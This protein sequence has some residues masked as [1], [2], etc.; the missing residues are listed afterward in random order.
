MKLISLLIFLAF[1]LTDLK[2]NP[3]LPDTLQVIQ[4]IESAQEHQKNGRAEA[5][6][7]GLRKAGEMAKELNFQRG[8]LMYAGHYTVFL[9]NQLRYEEAL[10]M[11]HI[12]LEIASRLNDLQRIGYAYNNIS[13]QYQAMGKLQ[14][15]ANNLMNALEISSRV[16]NPGAAHL[17]DRRK[18]YNNLSSLLLDMNDL[19]K[20]L[21]YA[22][23]A[24]EIAEELQDSV[25]MGRS[26]V[27]ILVAEAMAGKLARAESHGL[28]LQAI[29]EASGDIEMIMKAY[30]NL[31]DIYRMQGRYATSLETF[32][33]AQLLLNKLPPGHEVYVTMGMS[34][35]YKDMGE[36][37]KADSHFERA[38]VLAREELAKPQLIELFLSGAEIKE[39][40]GAYR[41][42]LLL[43]KQ[44]ELLNDS[45]RNQETH[46]SIQELEV[47]YQTAEKE[48]ALAERDLM[49]SEQVSELERKNKWFFLSAAV[50]FLLIILVVFNRLITVQ[51][52]KTQVSEQA[53]RILA[54]QL[55]GEE[56][57]RARTARELHDGV[58]S[59]LSAAKLHINA[60]DSHDRNAFGLVGQLI[61]TA[62]QEVRNISHNLAPGQ[63]LDEGLSSATQEFCRRM[64]NSQLQF[65]FYQIGDLPE[66]DKSAELLLY[67]IIQETV[68]NVVKHADA[69]EVI[70]QLEGEG[71]LLSITIEDNG[72]GFDP[73]GLGEKG[74]GLKNLAY[75]IQ[76]L[77][78]TYE[79]NSS[80][81]KGTSVY[82]YI[83]ASK[84]PQAS[85]QRLE[86][87]YA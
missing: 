27:N 71:S 45:L 51:K 25:A 11:A 53:N 59:I 8:M 17:G 83:D 58:A 38:L 4:L 75:R 16:E 55:Q 57:E 31:G 86:K 34:A 62:V 50:A 76:V 81:G 22:Q 70:V 10:E 24:Y 5:A 41:D 63:V 2:G 46:A 65:E 64:K 28:Q 85:K 40:L 66:L 23:K 15:A 77:N 29:G 18:Y 49:I 7:D 36:F 32:Q 80:P 78:G 79:I 60:A 42:A 73:E 3:S 30:N 54:A 21:Q 43:R 33:K 12:Q 26:L 13:L 6:E 39:S 9:Y 14:L 37:Q 1:V 84:I 48:K 87:Q 68:T 67:R 69:S 47:K 44:Y 61:E 56:T 20:G 52:H 82:I 19:D 74:I 72:K 35:T